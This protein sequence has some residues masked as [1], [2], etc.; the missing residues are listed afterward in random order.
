M[1]NDT[2]RIRLIDLAT[3]YSALP[4]HPPANYVEPPNYTVELLLKFLGSNLPH[5]HVRPLPF[6]PGTQWQYSNT[7]FGTLGVVMERISGM[8]Y[9]SLLIK[10]FCDS[11]NMPD[12]RVYLD[13]LQKTRLAYG[14]DSTGVT[15][16]YLETSPGFYGAGGNYSTMSDMIKYL[17]WNMGFK[18]TSLNELLDTLHKE[19]NYA[20]GDTTAWQGLAW[21]MNYLRHGLPKKYIWKDGQ[22]EG[23]TSFVCWVKETNT[24]VVVMSNSSIVVD[25]VGIDILRVLN[26][27]PTIIGITNISGEIPEKFSLQQN[28]PNPFNPS[29]VIR[30]SLS[31]NSFVTLKVY[32]VL[33]NE[34]AMLV[35]EKQNAGTYDYQFSAVKYQLASG[36]YYYKLF[37]DKF[38]QIKRMVLLK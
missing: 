25:P 26:P 16:F 35:N 23:Y 31:E 5:Y 15:P 21:Q 20:F 30:Y 19:R 9:D 29:T 4:H 24:G 33:G 34:V 10:I 38:S 8:S 1:P 2:F 17:A 12:T 11:L 6:Q 28:Y 18:H 22:S 13:S 7:G 27:L 37:T 32:D 36:V 3:H 14:Y